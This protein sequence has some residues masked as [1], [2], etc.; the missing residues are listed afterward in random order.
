MLNW[1][2]ILH[3]LQFAPSEKPSMLVILAEEEIVFID[4]ATQDWPVFQGPYLSSLHYSAVTCASY[5]PNVQPD[6]LEKIK[7]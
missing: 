1:L 6:V 4:L 5:I 2:E 7:V 3:N